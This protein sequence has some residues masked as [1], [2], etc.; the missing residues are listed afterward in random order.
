MPGP[1]DVA[2][3][4][5]FPG[6]NTPKGWFPAIFAWRAYTN[7]TTSITSVG[8]GTDLS[9][10]P[11]GIVG[12]VYYHSAPSDPNVRKTYD[13]G[14]TRPYTFYMPDGSTRVNATSMSAQ[15]YNNLVNNLWAS[16]TY[17]T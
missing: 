5:L 17:P 4:P 7:P 3:T 12:M 10:I 2:P 13:Y 11:A 15:A 9:A 6:W 8:R 1:G 14:D 16:D